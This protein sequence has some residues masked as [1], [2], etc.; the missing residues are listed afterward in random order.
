MSDPW[1]K[2]MSAR[3]PLE[4]HRAATP[5]ELFFDLVFVVAVAQV[6]A[7]LHHALAEGHIGDG[8]A[9]YGMVFFLI[10]WAWMQWTWFATSFDNDDVAYRVSTFVTM[11]G[12]LV[13]A[14]GVS[15][16]FEKGDFRTCTIGYVIMRLA[17]VS[18]WLRA[19]FAD[20]QHRRDPLGIAIGVVVF[21][22]GWIGRLWLTGAPS[23]VAF[24][25]L[26]AAEVALP[27]V[28]GRTGS[29]P[30]HLHHIIERYSLFT[31]IVLGES[32]LA[33]TLAVR[34]GMTR[35]EGSGS[36]IAVAVG[37]M[38]IVCAMWWLYF[39]QPAREI[40]TDSWL[41]LPW[42]HGHLLLFAST[43]AVGAGLAATID[44]VTGETHGMSALLAGAVTA[45]PVA[46][47]LMSV[48][49]AHVLPLRRP[50]VYRVLYPVTA[51]LVLLTSF[52][53]QPVPLIAVLMLVAVIASETA[54]RSTR[55]RRAPRLAGR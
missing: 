13:L 20:R 18:Q 42:G 51:L 53:T 40:R 7:G 16:V 15:E 8:L 32:V 37:G 39:A 41:V 46:A 21:Q 11:F 27:I 38:V 4:R 29:A 45:V 24:F 36:L 23:T 33:A 43:A 10:W 44:Y 30:W 35:G 26:A 1:L 54:D 3:S 12:V 2:P 14:A 49:L 55:E 6:A 19:G 47:F 17:A 22:A 31:I 28:I 9:A 25:V 5:L 34:E 50:L 48:W 52:T